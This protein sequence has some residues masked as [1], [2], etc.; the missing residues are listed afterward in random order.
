MTK[1]R[2]E[3]FSD[4]VIAIIITITILLIDLPDGNDIQALM[5]I[6]PLVACY[7]I[8]FILVGVNWVNHHH[9]FQ[10][11]G[12]VN[13]KILWAN[14]LYLFVLSFLPVT[15]GW[16]GK[17]LFSMLPVR[18]YVIANLAGAGSYLLLEKAIVHSSD[19][20][21][22]K[23][24]ISESRKELW[25]FAVEALALIASF[26]PGV[27]YTSCPLLVVA[28]APWIIPDLR[29]KRVFEEAQRRQD[30]GTEGE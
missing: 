28:V 29:M 10:V 13:G 7:L 25:T 22:L 11:A 2:L 27:H 4:G 9:L 1:G 17:S 26:I 14:L 19:C 18:V 6:M 3:A 5:G 24:A 8:S 21:I 30:A 15:T 20:Y 23:E 16:V 12:S